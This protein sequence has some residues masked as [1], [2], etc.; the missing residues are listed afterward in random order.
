MNDYFQVGLEPKRVSF[1]QIWQ[2]QVKGG[3]IVLRAAFVSKQ[4]LPLQGLYFLSKDLF[5]KDFSEFASPDA[6]D[7]DELRN[8]LEHRFVTLT[9]FGMERPSNNLHK[10]VGLAEFQKKSMKL[11]KLSRAALV[12]LSLAMNHEEKTHKSRKTDKYNEI[13]V[14]IISTP[15]YRN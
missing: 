7:L 4:N 12:Y 13:S 3:D 10:R 5:D 2:Y 1:R 9:D 14:P 15:I 11:L 8:F 6:K